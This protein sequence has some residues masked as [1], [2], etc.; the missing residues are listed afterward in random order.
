MDDQEIQHRFETLEKRLAVLE[1]A[2]G[3]PPPLQTVSKEVSIKEFLLSKKPESDREKTRAIAYY[4]ERF[5]G[6]TSFTTEDIEEG[7]RNAKESMSKNLSD[8]IGKNV[9]RGYMMEAKE[10]KGG[11]KAWTLTT[12]GERDVES[13]FTKSKPI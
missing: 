9:G 1:A 6:Y 10:K 13:G 8:T 3:T 11:K 5:K 2:Q 4:L 12:S 7:Y